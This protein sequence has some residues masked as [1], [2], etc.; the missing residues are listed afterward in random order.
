MATFGSFAYASR[1]SLPR[2][3]KPTQATLTVSLGLEET[4]RALLSA[5]TELM[6]KC[7]RFIARKRE[8]ETGFEIIMSDA[9]DERRY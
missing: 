9:G 5:A 6:Q 1:W 8:A 4:S 3:R 7:L 2:P